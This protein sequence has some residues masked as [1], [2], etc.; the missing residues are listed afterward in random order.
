MDCY[1]V[2][3]ELDDGPHDV[4]IPEYEWTHMVEGSSVLNEKLLNPLNINKVNISSP[5]ES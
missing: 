2:T 1:N 4:N 5:R 3:R